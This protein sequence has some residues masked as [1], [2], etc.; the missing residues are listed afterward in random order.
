MDLAAESMAE[1]HDTE[2]TP[3]HRAMELGR[4]HLD[5]IELAGI[6]KPYCQ[7]IAAEVGGA[8]NIVV[9]NGSEGV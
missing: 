4:I 7:R 5:R 6:A 9:R 3:G 8:V 2:W 1:Q